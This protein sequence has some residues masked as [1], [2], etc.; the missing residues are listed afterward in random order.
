ML[1]QIDLS[2]WKTKKQILSELNALGVEIKERALRLMI[3]K[4]NQDYF[5][6]IVEDLI[7]HSDKGYKRTA[8][9]AEILK[10]REDYKKRA[11]NMLWKYTQI[12]KALGEHDNIKL[13]L[14]ADGTFES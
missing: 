12:G 5:D 10:R 2:T 13:E 1:D 9:R 11:L 6:G 3:E 14:S 4:H 7:I 8:D